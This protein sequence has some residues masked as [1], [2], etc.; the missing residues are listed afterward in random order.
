MDLIERKAREGT[1][2]HSPRW[3]DPYPHPLHWTQL[4]GYAAIAALALM[5]GC[6]MPEEATGIAG[7]NTWLSTVEH[8]GHK[9]VVLTGAHRG[10][11][12]H[13]PDCPCRKMESAQ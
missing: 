11:L 5:S 3:H 2:A 7:S 9:W 10:A 13:H 6:G 8:D 1:T 4:L 12:Q